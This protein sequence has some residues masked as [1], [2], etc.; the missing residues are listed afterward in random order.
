MVSGEDP[1]LAFE[2]L[3]ADRRGRLAR[4]LGAERL[5]RSLE[6]HGGWR[7]CDGCDA[8][9]QLGERHRNAV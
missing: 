1:M 4:G 2:E 5:V 7:L 3:E 9:D 8:L 6:D